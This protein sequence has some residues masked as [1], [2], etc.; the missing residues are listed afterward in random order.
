MRWLWCFHQNP[1][2]ATWVRGSEFGIGLRQSHSHT[3]AE[4]AVFPL[5]STSKENK[6]ED[7]GTILGFG[8]NV[9]FL[10][11]I[12]APHSPCQCREKGICAC[13]FAKPESMSTL[14][15]GHDNCRLARSQRTPT[16]FYTYYIRIKEAYFHLHS[17]N[18]KKQTYCSSV[19][20]YNL[21]SW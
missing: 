14:Q 6:E 11:H 3:R 7:R 15:N 2:W 17:C 20:K 9:P 10:F 18:V 12:T 4:L 19:R 1:L 5:S 21:S 13:V 8:S 16:C